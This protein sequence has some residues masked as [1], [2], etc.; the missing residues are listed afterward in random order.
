MNISNAVID[1]NKQH[2]KVQLPPIPSVH[3]NISNNKFYHNNG[4][5]SREAKEKEIPQQ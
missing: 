3:R 4:I 5:T 1:D 2:K